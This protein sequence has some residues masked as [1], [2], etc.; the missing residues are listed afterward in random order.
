MQKHSAQ[1]FSH[2]GATHTQI[3]I[4]HPVGIDINLHTHTN[5][6]C[7]YTKEQNKTLEKD[8]EA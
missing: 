6:C 2:G 1:S 3:H 5:R 8:P 4:K 7:Q